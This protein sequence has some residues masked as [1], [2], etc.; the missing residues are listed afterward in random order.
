MSVV[1]RLVPEEVKNVGGLDRRARG[2]AGTLLVGIGVWLFA[3]GRA[4]AGVALLAG[5]GLLFNAVTGFCGMNA[6]LGVDT[7]SRED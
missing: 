2:V 5:V 1:D 3:G 6:L 7:C 4:Y